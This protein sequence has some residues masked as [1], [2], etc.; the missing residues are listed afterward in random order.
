MFLAKAYERFEPKKSVAHAALPSSPAPH[1]SYFSPLYSSSHEALPENLSS[2][3]MFG[4]FVFSCDSHFFRPG[5]C[6]G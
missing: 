6:K 4:H 1:C 5:L 3:K 2:S